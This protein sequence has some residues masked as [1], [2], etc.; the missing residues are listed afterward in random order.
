MTLPSFTNK[1][2]SEQYYIAF[3]FDA[4]LDGEVIDSAVITVV[5]EDGATV[6]TLLDDTK[7]VLSSYRVYLWVKSGTSGIRYKITCKVTGENGSIYEMDA[8]QYVEEL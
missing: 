8:Y 7:Q 1:Q 3:D 5:D 6:E 4:Y 2:P